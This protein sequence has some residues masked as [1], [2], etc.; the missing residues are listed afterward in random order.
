MKLSR[1]EIRTLRDRWDESTLDTVRKALC[2]WAFKRPNQ[3]VPLDA[4]QLASEIEIDGNAYVDLRGITLVVQL[5]YFAVSGVC[6]DAAA[7]ERAGAFGSYSTFD[8]CLFRNVKFNTNLYSQFTNC[9]FRH[10]NLR[11]AALGGPF[12]NVDFSSCNLTNVNSD[13]TSFTNCNFTDSNLKSAHLTNCTFTDCSFGGNTFGR[14]SLYRS[15]FVGNTPDRD[16]LA[17]TIVD[18]VSW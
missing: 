2:K 3:R 18:R 11:D 1:S 16:G 12:V 13:Q 17:D 4:T 15:K 14:G 8:D 7:F 9:S 5:N 10:S 6:F